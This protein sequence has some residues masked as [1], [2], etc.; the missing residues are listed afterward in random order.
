MD[1]CVFCKIISGKLP[2]QKVYENDKIVAFLTIQPVNPGHTLVVPR[3]HHADLLETPDEVL[4]DI[5]TRSK[6]IATAIMN[7]VKADGFNL[8]CNTKPAAG[9]AVFHTHVHIIP[10]FSKDGLKNWPHKEFSGEE[11][12][13]VA[14][15]IKKAL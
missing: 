12:Q 11:M 14:D 6:K 2:A 9:Q 1:D 5:I 3:E 10:R 15:S 7:A 4:S 13:K 8:T